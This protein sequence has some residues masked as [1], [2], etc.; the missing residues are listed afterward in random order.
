MKSLAV[1]IAIACFATTISPAWAADAI[2]NTGA[3]VFKR[4]SSEGDP[5]VTAS[6]TLTST[7]TVPDRMGAQRQ[8]SLVLWCTS[9]GRLALSTIWPQSFYHSGPKSTTTVEWKVD[10]RARVIEA[11]PTSSSGQIIGLD[12]AVATR[13]FA[14]KLMKSSALLIAIGN[15]EPHFDTT[16]ADEAISRLYQACG[17]T[18]R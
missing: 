10:R 3:W 1:A 16:G 5:T 7:N 9:S 2:L 12:G 17:I 4:E 14:K 18:A 11:W 6:I 15:Y 8:V 13:P